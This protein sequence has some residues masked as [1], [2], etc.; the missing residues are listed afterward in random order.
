[1]HLMGTKRITII[2]DESLFDRLRRA[3]KVDERHLSVYLR[4]LLTQHCDAA[5]RTQIACACCGYSP[6]DPDRCP[7]PE[8]ACQCDPR[9]GLK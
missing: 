3:A 6:C 7:V 9:A 5:S 4:R 8:C 2:V 1:M